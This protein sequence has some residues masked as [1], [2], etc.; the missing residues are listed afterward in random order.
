MQYFRRYSGFIARFMVALTIFL[1]MPMGVAQ[2]GLVSTDALIDHAQAD[3]DRARVLSFLG[4]EQIRDQIR[5]LGVDPDEAAARV[6][7]LSDVEISKLAGR[8]D[9]LPAGQDIVG[10]LVGAVVVIFLVLLVTDILGLTHIFP[11]VRR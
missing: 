11:F 4:R 3:N 2:A 9:A 10:P 6:S 1:F 7:A 5:G 8:I